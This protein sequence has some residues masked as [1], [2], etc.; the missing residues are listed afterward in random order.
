MIYM[1]IQRQS[2]KQVGESKYYFI[3]LISLGFDLDG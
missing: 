1:I 2:Q 3:A